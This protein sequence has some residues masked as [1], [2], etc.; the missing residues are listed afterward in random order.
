MTK[1]ILLWHSRKSVRVRSTVELRALEGRSMGPRRP[2]AMSAMSC[3][4]GNWETDVT[5]SSCRLVLSTSYPIPAFSLPFPWHGQT[6]GQVPLQGMIGGDHYLY[7]SGSKL[8]RKAVAASSPWRPT[9]SVRPILSSLWITIDIILCSPT[10]TTSQHRNMGRVSAYGV[11]C[12]CALFR[13]ALV[14][15]T[16]IR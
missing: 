16:T 9:A 10:R 15:R 2:E 7:N 3:V 4:S 14:W 5:K 6:S 1:T 13:S 8:G 11:R 12:W